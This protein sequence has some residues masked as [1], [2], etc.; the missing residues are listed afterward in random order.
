MPMSIEEMKKNLQELR[1]MG[2]A[3][4]FEARALQANQ[5]HLAFLDAFSMLLQDEVDRNKS[6]VSQRRFKRSGLEERKAMDDFDWKFN[7]QIP[8]K[9]CFELLTL[10]FIQ[11]GEDALL[12]GHPGTGKSHIAQVI[13]LQ[14]TDR[15]YNVIYRE[16]H[17]LFNE[18][19][20][21]TQFK[22][23]KKL[24]D[25]YVKAD[26][27]VIDDLFLRKST[28]PDA[29]DVLQEIIMDRYS[30]KKSTFIT[31]NRVVEDWGKCLGDNVVASAILD[32]VMHHS[33][34]L[35]FS[36]K[37]W[38]LKESASRMLE[39]GKEKS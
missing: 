14:A 3:E 33:H 22:S 36:G 1:L 26:L 21:A 12:L 4:S 16:A 18:M 39:K 15:G 34:F 8:K 38:R 23:A 11:Q 20:E 30:A 6:A 37:S 29:A 27:L 7:P 2:M 13:V 35:K 25:S 19:F 24:H 17:K 32:R 9:E 5:G 28:H 31:S 10:K